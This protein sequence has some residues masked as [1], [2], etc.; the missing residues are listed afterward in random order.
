MTSTEDKLQYKFLFLLS[1]VYLAIDINVQGF[2]SLM[3]FIRGEFQITRAQGGLYYTS[4]F[5]IATIIAIFSG[6]IV[7]RIGSKKGLVFG[8]IAVGAL[9]ILHPLAPYFFILLILA[10]FTGLAFSIITPSLN[11]AV[12]V[13]VTQE[14]R[15]TSMGIIQMG[16][17]AGGFLGASLLPILGENFSWRIAILFSGFLAI[18]IGLFIFR[19]YRGKITILNK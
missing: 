9:I 17:G 11:K 19:F 2:L 15:A 7:D 16:G 6:R 5:L 12:M 13:K 8:T 3:P 10:F 14:N 1:T 4:Y 18:C